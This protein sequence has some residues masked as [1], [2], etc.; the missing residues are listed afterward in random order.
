MTATKHRTADDI[1]RHLVRLLTEQLGRR[2][3]AVVTVAGES[4]YGKTTCLENARALLDATTV[5]IQ[6]P[7]PLGTQ[8]APLYQ[9]LYPLVNAIEQILSNPTE[10]AKR[11][12]VLN[13]GLSVLG[14]IPLIGSLF[15]V[16]KEVLRDMRE[17]RR[18]TQSSTPTETQQIAEILCSIAEQSPL[19]IMLDDAQWIDA[20][21]LEVIEYLLAS[22]R[23]LPLAIVLAY[24][25]SVV[26]AQ[27]AW[28]EQWLIQHP[29]IE[30][31]ELPLLDRS[32]LQQLALA[33]LPSY[34]PDPT[35]DEWLLHQSGG[36]PA[37]AVEYLRY[38]QR[39]S[40][41]DADGRLRQDVLR[42]SWRPAS[43]NVLIEQIVTAIADEDK[44]T[45]AICAAEGA[46]FSVFVLSQL[47]QLDPVTTVRR[48]RALQQRT[49]VIRSMG[50]QR[51]YGVE[52]TVYRFTH[53]GYYRFF[54]EYLEHEE[55][56][57]I[58][59]RI[60]AIL[61]QQVLTAS[62]E[63]LAEQLA[64]IIAAHYI[65]ASNRRAAE[66]VMEQ[67]YR[68]ASQHGHALIAAFALETMGRTSENASQPPVDTRAFLDVL[69]QIVDLW[70]AGDITSAYRLAKHL[71][72]DHT[73]QSERV[74]AEMVRTRIELDI[75][76]HQHA[77]DR[78][79]ESISRA[80][81]TGLPELESLAYSLAVVDDLIQD[82]LQHGWDHA[83]RAATHAA[84]AS[85][86]AKLVALSNA[87][88]VLSRAGH[89]SH[90]ALA[91]AAHRI[92][93]RLGYRS[94]ADAF[95]VQSPV[96]RSSSP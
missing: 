76:E 77:H 38:F 5:I 25:P 89:P 26:Q 58:H 48:L 61:E 28:M 93:L 69:G 82:R 15:D 68:D 3:I 43:L 30:Q 62:D 64:P 41:F 37:I 74:L 1:P 72:L 9:P 44:L 18:E 55:R 60:A 88:I 36:V 34:H 31:F 78:L 4:G 86:L 52:T 66:R 84:D 19:V 12:L 39:H 90:H 16:T 81:A 67:L 83:Q 53:A 32:Q 51:L 87:A 47:L 71:P 27:N 57:E 29:E 11:R 50:M 46:R 8:T 79:L 14:M 96:H 21:S 59:S 10:K 35:F 45:L 6:C 91:T 85:P 95:D 23:N 13:I 94:I 7:A 17:Y 92:A 40:P 54:V 2:Q 65:E 75:G 42:T 63:A 56:I 22:N 73:T 24:E 33:M 70:F 20:A 80:R 49:G